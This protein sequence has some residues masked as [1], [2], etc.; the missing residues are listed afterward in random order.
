MAILLT[1]KA[2][3]QPWKHVPQVEPTPTQ[4]AELLPLGILCMLQYTRH[5]ELTQN[6]LAEGVNV[7]SKARAKKEIAKRAGE[8]AQ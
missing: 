8:V 5:A 7:E 4:R 3:P 2:V 6:K 1:P